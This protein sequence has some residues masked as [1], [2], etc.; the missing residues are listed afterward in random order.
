LIL[1][2]K[3]DADALE[4]EREIERLG[5][6][7]K[8]RFTGHLEQ[9]EM[10]AVYSGARVFVFPS[11]YE[12]YGLP[13]LEAMAC[14]VPVVCSN[15]TSLPEIAGDAALLVDPES[16]KALAEAMRTAAGDEQK[17]RICIER[18]LERAR[19]LNRTP[20]AARI[21]DILRSVKES[22][23]PLPPAP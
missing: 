3:K 16:P 15:R 11:L 6:K 10:R 9:Q 19:E 14:G 13:V 5:L 22:P 4:V 8:A 18:G 2:G 21:L 1:G 12:G 7:E 17:R 20:C 23:W